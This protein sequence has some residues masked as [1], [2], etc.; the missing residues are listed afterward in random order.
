MGHMVAIHPD[1]DKDC[2]YSPQNLGQ[3]RYFLVH[4]NLE[5]VC[6]SFFGKEITHALVTTHLDPDVDLSPIMSDYQL[7][8]IHI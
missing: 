2:F 4:N 8:L 1:Y 3:L 5:P 7:S 6:E